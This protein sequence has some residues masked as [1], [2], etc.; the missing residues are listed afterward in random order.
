MN[1]GGLDGGDFNGEG[2]GPGIEFSMEIDART[3]V[4]GGGGGS[5]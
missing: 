1:G 5:T 3:I 2:R 4:E